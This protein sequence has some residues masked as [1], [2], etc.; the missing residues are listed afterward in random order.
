MERCQE[1]AR[2]APPRSTCGGNTGRGTS[3][4]RSSPTACAS[5][6]RNET[7]EMSPPAEYPLPL[8]TRVHGR[9]VPRNPHP[10]SRIERP[11]GASGSPSE[12]PPTEGQGPHVVVVDRY[13]AGRIGTDP[14]NAPPGPSDFLCGAHRK[15]GAHVHKKQAIRHLAALQIASFWRTAMLQ[16][17]KTAPGF[18]EPPHYG[19]HKH[20]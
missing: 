9:V 7:D 11:L 12:G 13:A 17:A 19:Q 14:Q 8:F 5:S 15:G 2:C 3:V 20:V 4:G 10:G 1:R 16:P 18:P 6:D